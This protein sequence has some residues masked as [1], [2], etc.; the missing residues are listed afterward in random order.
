MAKVLQRLDIL[1]FANTA[2]YRA[3]MRDTQQSTTTLF[4]AIK[5]DAANMAKVG[6]AAFAGMAAAG[7]V[8]IGAMIKEQ[9]ELGNEITR[10]SR[11]ANTG[12]EDMQKLAIAAKAVGVE[13]D[14]LGDIYKDTQDK[15]GDFLSTGGGAMADYFENVAPLVGQTAEQFR[16]LSGPDALQLYYDGLQKANLSQ[17]ELVFYLEAIASDASALIPLLHDGGAGFDVWANAAANAGAIMDAETI[18]ATKELQAS[19]DLMML[20][21][22]GAKTQ[23]TRAIIPVLSDLAGALVQDANAANIARAAGENLVGGLKVLAKVGI[24][25]VAVFDTVGRVVGGVAATISRLTSGI[26]LT[27][28][29]IVLALKLAKNFRAADDVARIAEQDIKVNLSDY[30]DKIAFIDKLGNGPKNQTVAAVVKLNDAQSALNRTY[31]KTGQQLQAEAAAAEAAAKAVDKHSAAVKKAQET[32]GKTK[33]LSINAKVKA[34]AEKYNFAALEAQYDL[35]YGLLSGVHMQESR[36]NPNAKGPATKYG[37]AKGGFQFLDATAQRFGVTNSYNMEQA[38]VGAA[39]YLKFLLD[40]YSGNVAK[41]I[42]AYNTGEDNVDK[43]DLSLILSDRW[44]RNKKTGVGQTKEYTQN[45]LAYMQSVRA[46]MGESSQFIYDSI[47]KESK[48]LQDAAEKAAQIE[49]KKQQQR[50]QII[51]QYADEETQINLRLRDELVKIQEAG[52]SEEDAVKYANAAIAE[53]NKAL[54]R[55]ELDKQEFIDAQQQKL[56]V[57]TEWKETEY[58]LILRNAQLQR[59]EYIA[60]QELT[61][62]QRK[63]AIDAI[64]ER[65]EYEIAMIEWTRTKEL[66]TA[67]DN[68]KSELELIEQRY[69]FERQELA[70]NKQISDDIRES[71]AAQIDRDEARAVFDLQDAAAQAWDRQQ[72]EFNNTTVDYDLQQKWADRLRVIQTALEAEVIAVEDAEAAKHA[73]RLE[74]ERASNELAVTSAESMATS[75]SDIFKNLLGEQSRVYRVMF[76]IEKGIAIARSVMSIQTAIAQ[77]AASL[78]FPANLG[79]MVTIAANAASI[80]SNIQAVRMPAALQGQAHNGIDSI[81]REGTY[82]LDEGERVVK[83]AENRQLGNFLDKVD[84]QGIGNQ[85][86]VN[87]YNYSSEKVTESINDKGELDLIIGEQVRKQLPRE[88][89]DPYSSTNQALKRNYHLQ[90]KLN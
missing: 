81:P 71:R 41:A 66:E 32:A 68:Q 27:D 47:Q 15:I 17:S 10:L 77:G 55:I 14:T 73:A 5:A 86:V 28:G 46:T 69:K 31:G 63:F 37:T 30:A 76:A 18:R 70:L 12:V 50:Q 22:D 21:Y 62:D 90:R 40:R 49:E 78:P 16:A 57:L 35:P 29:A 25:V 23:F 85:M 61:D 53:S 65:A 64:N 67:F 75:V 34:N 56:A 72:A 43:Y 87:V 11:I 54:A 51:L 84:N 1:L 13:Q 6:A 89:N 45:V 59:Q 4:G 88:I 24:G 82:L 38:T 60:D 8:A 48:D 58:D 19:T 83:R 3:E 74:Y 52:F 80:V 39:K 79:A 20:S 7:T 42:A 44:A 33:A 2:Q 36:G 9:I 26:S